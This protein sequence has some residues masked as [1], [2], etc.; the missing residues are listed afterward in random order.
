MGNQEL[1]L[2]P[3]RDKH[4]EPSHKEK[5][6][7]KVQ[8]LIISDSLSKLK[9]KEREKL[10]ISSKIAIN[11]VKDAGFNPEGPRFVADEIDQIQ[12]VIHTAVKEEAQLVIAIGGTGLAKRDITIEA[13]KP[14]FT[15]ELPGFGELFRHLTYQEIGTVALMTR[16]TAGIIANTVITCLPGSPNAV[17]LGVP[18]ILKEIVHILM[19]IK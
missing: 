4:L 10:D 15:K 1:E 5:I 9:E 3:T 8:I 11:L 2:K 14:L 6:P 16:A 18:L 17:K 12:N 13:L 19:H 7:V